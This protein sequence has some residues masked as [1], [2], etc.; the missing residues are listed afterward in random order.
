MKRGR[1][2]YQ[3]RACHNKRKNADVKQPTRN[4]V[5]HDYYYVFIRSCFF[6]Q[7][8]KRRGQIEAHANPAKCVCR[9][10]HG[11]PFPRPGNIL[12]SPPA[13]FSTVRRIRANRIL[14]WTNPQ[15]NKPILFASATRQLSTAELWRAVSLPLH[16]D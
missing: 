7:Q 8:K 11:Q 16:P 14:F 13:I 15:K 9:N 12:A 2:K 3:S 6:I 1:K 5:K 4:E 10:G